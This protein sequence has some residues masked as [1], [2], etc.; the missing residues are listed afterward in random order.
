[1]GDGALN[2]KRRFSLWPE[3]ILG[4]IPGLKELNVVCW[5]LFVLFLFVPLVLYLFV[6]YKVGAKFS[7]ILPIDFIYFY[8]IGRLSNEYP[9]SHFYD[10]PLQV[11]VLN[12]IFQLRGEVWGGSPYPPLVGKIFGL[13]ARFS[14]ATAYYLWLVTSLALYLTGILATLK[15]VF[16]RERLKSSLVICFALAFPSFLYFTL[17][18]GQIATIAVFSAGLAIYEEREGKSFVSGLALSI[19]SYKPSLLVILFPMLVLTRR[20]RALAGFGSGVLCWILLSTVLS[21]VQIWPTYARFLIEFAGRAGINGASVI[22]RWEYLDLYSFSYI[23][24]DGRSHIGLI[25]L[26]IILVG[27]ATWIG[28]IFWKSSNLE[29][30]MQFLVWAIGLTWT[31]LLNVYVPIYDSVLAVLAVA[32]TLGALDKLHRRGAIAAVAL[33]GLGIFV[34]SALTET[35]A[36]HHNIQ[37]LTLLLGCLGLIQLATMQSILKEPVEGDQSGLLST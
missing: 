11:K 29:P 27:L 21:G 10:L 16:P 7:D 13:Y 4:P 18:V 17:I 20:F 15:A 35:I 31:L 22:K 14:I 8:G 1:M 28:V 2:A 12:S 19:L 25:L 37:I 24:P 32:L 36:K 30:S 6:K 5:C 3:K 9:A 34:G 33:L 26:G 23:V